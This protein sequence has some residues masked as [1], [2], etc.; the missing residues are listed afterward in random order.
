MRLRY[1]RGGVDYGRTP[2]GE[3]RRLGFV[4]SWWS[5]W[6]KEKVW[7]LRLVVDGD[8]YIYR[9]ISVYIDDI[10][11]EFIRLFRRRMSGVELSGLS[12]CFSQSTRKEAIVTHS[13]IRKDCLEATNRQLR[14]SWW[15]F[16]LCHSNYIRMPRIS[17]LIGPA[18]YRSI[19]DRG[20]R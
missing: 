10:I 12:V 2:R 14:N 18:I 13:L 15:L 19:S 8:G 20:A 9:Y 7:L 3:D 4:A 16:V 1:L 6:K 17:D 11:D 5:S